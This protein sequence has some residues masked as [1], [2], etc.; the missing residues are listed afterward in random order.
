MPIQ[1]IT[2]QERKAILIQVP[3]VT[4]KP[5][6]ISPKM[7]TINKIDYSVRERAKVMEEAP[8]V[9]VTVDTETPETDVEMAPPKKP[10]AYAP[11]KSPKIVGLPGKFL[12]NLSQL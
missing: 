3:K 12:S 11:F 1:R 2:E 6:P 5:T 8:T 9:S 4:A 10:R 7:S